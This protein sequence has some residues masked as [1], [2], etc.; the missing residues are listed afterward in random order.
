MQKAIFFDRDGV[1]IDDVHLLTKISQVKISNKVIDAF[2]MLKEMNYLLIVVSNQTVI[3]RGISTYDEVDII[4]DFINDV[5]I[6]KTSSRIEKFY[7]CPHHPE[8]TVEK[9]KTNCMCRKPKSGM[10][11][12][13]AKEF[14]IDLN[15][16][17]MIGDRISDIIAGHNA[18]CKTI[19]LL[20][21]AHNAKPIISDAM[22][23]SKTPDYKCSN[24]LEAINIIHQLDQN[25]K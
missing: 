7:Y 14:S 22:D 9:Y 25:S 24:L 12:D 18:G 21:G 17:W 11:Y 3:A 1:I 4:H 19:N 8:A 6:N 2:T 15:H 10:L 16:S 20:T 13:A 23:L 5:L